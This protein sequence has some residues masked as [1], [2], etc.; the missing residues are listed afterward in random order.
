MGNGG[1]KPLPRPFFSTTASQAGSRFPGGFVQPPPTNG[2]SSP[3]A[4]TSAPTPF[5]MPFTPPGSFSAQRESTPEPPEIHD[6][7]M[8]SIEQDDM[9]SPTKSES[10]TDGSPV[11]QRRSSEKM[12]GKLMQRIKGIAGKGKGRK[13]THDDYFE[14]SE[15]TSRS[16]T[17][18]R[19][20]RKDSHISDGDDE[21][22]V[23]LSFCWLEHSLTKPLPYVSRQVPA[24]ITSISLRRRH[25]LVMCRTSSLAI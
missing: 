21:L 4:S 15:S 6:V 23:C 16:P 2:H 20:R 1:A 10:H 8:T 12:G 24:S 17:K 7:S 14:E 5:P 9:P 11:R 25:R 19:R 13:G 18:R 3:F 22:E